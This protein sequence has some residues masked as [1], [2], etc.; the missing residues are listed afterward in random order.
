VLLLMLAPHAVP[1]LV[2]LFLPLAAWMIASR[3][4]DWQDLLAATFVTVALAVPVL[5]AAAAVETW[6]SPHLLLALAP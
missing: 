2:A 1:E 5:V 3:R 4:G 6:V